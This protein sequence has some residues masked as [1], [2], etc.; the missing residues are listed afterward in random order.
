M[1]PRGVAYRPKYVTISFDGTEIRTDRRGAVRIGTPVEVERVTTRNRA[2]RR[3][4]QRM[5]ALNAREG[6]RRSAKVRRMALEASRS[7]V[8]PLSTVEATSDTKDGQDAP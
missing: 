8:E 5:D 7:P 1:T 4:L 3:R 2:E 6:A